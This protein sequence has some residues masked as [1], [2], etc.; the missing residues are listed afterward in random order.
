[1]AMK[2]AQPSP[3]KTLAEKVLERK[4]RI[5]EPLN[6]ETTFDKDP[7]KNIQTLAEKAYENSPAEQERYAA[8][9]KAS[10]EKHVNGSIEDLW[11][12]LADNY[13]ETTAIVEGILH[14][15]A[16]AKG[17]K[18]I[19]LEK[20]LKPATLSAESDIDKVHMEEKAKTILET[21]SKL[22]ALLEEITAKAA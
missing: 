20:F 6:A 7:N 5:N 10:L 17:E 15:F 11:K 16:G 2:N 9:I 12:Y 22:T 1:M 21:K 19:G 18:E 8:K 3:D 14:F 4:E 13:C